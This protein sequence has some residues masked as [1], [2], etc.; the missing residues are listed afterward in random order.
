MSKICPSCGK[1]LPPDAP[2]GLC[3]QCLLA[4]GMSDSANKTSDYTPLEAPSVAEVAAFFPQLEVLELLG[5]GGMGA[6]Y[7]ARQPGLDR[8]V[9]LKILPRRDDPTFAERFM[10]EARGS[11]SSAI[12][13]SSRSTISAKSATCTTS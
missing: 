13:A 4:H 3:P 9:A 10:R 11:P 2:G 5:A 12:P 7:K 1:S 8:L 6:V